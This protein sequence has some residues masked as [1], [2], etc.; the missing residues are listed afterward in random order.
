[1]VQVSI[2]TSTLV[3]VF[4]FSPRQKYVCFCSCRVGKANMDVPQ[5]SCLV[6]ELEVILGFSSSDEMNMA[7]GAWTGKAGA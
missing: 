4:Y 2:T 7:A 1:M 5:V 3:D 6:G